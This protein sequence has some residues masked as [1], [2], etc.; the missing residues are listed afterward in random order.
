ME[1][2]GKVELGE[3]VVAILL[4][5][6]DKWL[7][8]ARRVLQDSDVAEDVVQESVRRVLEHGRTFASS[9]DLRMYMGRT[10]TNTTMEFYHIR[11]RERLRNA[12]LNEMFLP[13]FAPDDP[14]ELLLLEEE[15][16][17]SVRVLR[18][19]RDGMRQLPSREHKAVSITILGPEPTSIRE[20]GVAHGIPYSTLRRQ[21]LQ[22]I[23][24]LRR[25][26]RRALRFA[27]PRR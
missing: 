15:R 27:P 18:L 11:K 23:R 9:E 10:I 5:H 3:R 4:R 17:R 13:V 1:E 12:P 6:G 16:R 24:R 26:V 22:G 19:I 21:S 20:A 7:R 25:H 2:S 14:H 8:F